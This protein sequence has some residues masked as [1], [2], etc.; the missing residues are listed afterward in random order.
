[1]REAARE[2]QGFETGATAWVGVMMPKPLPKATREPVDSELKRL[3]LTPGFVSD[4]VE[5]NGAKVKLSSKDYDQ[6]QQSA[7]EKAYEILQGMFTNSSYKDLPD[8]TK[9]AAVESLTRKVFDV[10]RTRL[11]ASL[12]DRKAKDELE[13]S[14]DLDPETM[15]FDAII[16]AQLRQ[17][18]NQN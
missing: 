14:L 18:Q 6:Y 3:N 12:G 5:V 9:R 10:Q 13:F 8:E 16:G 2:L 1:M 11:K 17:F 15:I 4:N 7:G